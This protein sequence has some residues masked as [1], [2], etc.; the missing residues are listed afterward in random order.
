MPMCL[1]SDEK[2]GEMFKFGPKELKFNIGPDMKIMFFMLTNT[3]DFFTAVT[4]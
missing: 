3:D 2:L 1:F 4:P